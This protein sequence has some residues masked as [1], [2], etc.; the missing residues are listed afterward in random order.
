M[1]NKVKIIDGHSYDSKTMSTEEIDLLINK[2]SPHSGDVDVAIQNMSLTID[3]LTEF[4][5]RYGV[6][7]SNHE[8]LRE[9]RDRLQAE[10]EKVRGECKNHCQSLADLIMQEHKRYLDSMEWI[11]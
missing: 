6:L 9:E 11:G 5:T 8:K 7:S 2:Y 4:K 3:R 10:L 1:I